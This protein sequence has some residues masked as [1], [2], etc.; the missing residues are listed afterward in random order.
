[1]EHPGRARPGSEELPGLLWG[2]RGGKS[3]R[4]ATA[5]DRAAYE[6]WRRK[7]PAGPRVEHTTW[8][9]E[10]ATV[11]GFFTWAVRQGLMDENPV[12]Q[13]VSRARSRSPR[14]AV[15]EMVP[16]ESSHTG[17]RRHVEWLT[18]GMYRQWRDAGV[19][20]FTAAG[21]PDGSFR[22]RFAS[23]NAAFTD[24]MIRTG[25]R[26]SEQTALSL[27]ELPRP[28]AGVLNAR[29]WLPAPVAKG[30]A[31]RHVYFPAG[32]LK[33]VWD[34]VEI[35]RARPSSRLARLVCMSSSRTGCSSRIRRSRWCVPAAGGC[36]S[37]GW[38]ALS[39]PGCW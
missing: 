20:G 12:I 21:L 7:D 22:G 39:V 37:P 29:A 34:Y 25:L 18:P 28:A 14:Q 2:S 38:A 23:R 10:V 8:D 3:W 32:V 4:D 30:G 27:Y 26:I 19:R 35:E 17:P 31:A 1:V 36:P 33:D 5:G 24:V 16:A 11:N 9:R 13:R 15:P 6:R